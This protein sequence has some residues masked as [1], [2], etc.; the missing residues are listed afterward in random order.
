MGAMPS[1]M[2]SARVAAARPLSAL[3][4]GVLLL[5]T[6]VAGVGGVGG[7]AGVGRPSAQPVTT[8]AAASTVAVVA[9]DRRTGDRRAATALGS[10]AGQQHA[11]GWTPPLPEPADLPAIAWQHPAGPAAPAVE[12]APTVI[13]LTIQV[14]HRGRAPPAGSLFL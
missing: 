5:L 12:A 7:F 14:S 1:R 3:I 2:S 6:V 4:S 10:P 8:V 13:A 9:G 11:A